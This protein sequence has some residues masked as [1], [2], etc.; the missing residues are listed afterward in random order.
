[1]RPRTPP[2]SPTASRFPSLGSRDKPEQNADGTTDLYLGPEGAGGQ[3]KQ[4]ARTVPGKGF[5][6]I[7]R[8][9]GPTEPRSTR[10]EPGRHRTGELSVRDRR[11]NDEIVAC[12]DTARYRPSDIETL[13]EVLPIGG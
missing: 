13:V 7:L 2:V 5:F 1:M 3:G 8:L 4:L 11:E 6:A 10:V 9:Y 12:S